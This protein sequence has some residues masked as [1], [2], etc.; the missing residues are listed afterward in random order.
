MG[1]SLVLKTPLTLSKVISLIEL[2]KFVVRL[3]VVGQD[4]QK[5]VGGIVRLI[6]SSKKNRSFGKY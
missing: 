5:H 3:E 2:R 6:A 4:K 1:S